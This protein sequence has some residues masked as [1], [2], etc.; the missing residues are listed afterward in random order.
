[1]AEYKFEDALNRLEEIV[2]DLE[3]GNLNLDDAIKKYE[4]GIKLAG[5]CYKKLEDTKKKVEV[6]VKDSSGRF[7]AKDFQETGLEGNA[8][9]GKP[10]AASKKKR[11][12]GEEL[13]F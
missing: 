8:V 5:I 3:S 9:T 10:K 6:L 13:M 2:T 12:R 1:M 7:L 4:E 11:P